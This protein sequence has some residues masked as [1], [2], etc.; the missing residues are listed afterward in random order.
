[1]VLGIVSQRF[2][3]CEVSLW[4]NLATISTSIATRNNA[5]PQSIER[6]RQVSGFQ[7][8]PKNIKER[9]H[10]AVQILEMNK[11]NLL[12]VTKYR[13][14]KKKTQHSRR[15]PKRLSTISIL[16]RCHYG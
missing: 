13:Y 3:Y 4:L 10:N 9:H 6:K 16:Q 1:M 11:P 15:G 14:S 5:R 2:L 8:D 7:K 12:G